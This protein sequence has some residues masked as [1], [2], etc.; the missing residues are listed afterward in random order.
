MASVTL[1]I[2]AG[3]RVDVGG[4]GLWWV[5]LNWLNLDSS[6]IADGTANNGLRNLRLSNRA[7]NS[8]NTLDVQPNGVT[9]AR[10]IELVE[11]WE[12]H[13][14]AIRFDAGSLFLELPGPNNASNVFRDAVE[15]YQWRA[16]DAKRV[17]IGTFI[18]SYNRLSTAERNATTLTL[19]DTTIDAYATEIRE[20]SRGVDYDFRLVL[21]NRYGIAITDADTIR[22]R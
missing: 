4:L 1:T 3:T 15:I 8:Q 19:S 17:E 22:T 10:S 5:N 12:T 16:S 7:S 13:D 20:L 21:Q 9:S 6:I 14:S 2:G 18:G 11:T